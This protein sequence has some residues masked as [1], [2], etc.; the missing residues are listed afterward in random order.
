MTKRRTLGK[1]IVA[2]TRRAN[3]EERAEGAQKCVVFG[4][5]IIVSRSLL[6]QFLLREFDHNL[7][8]QVLLLN[9]K[10]KI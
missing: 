4:Y 1:E 5:F 3:M 9:C 10:V 6:P 8:P 7:R 2:Q